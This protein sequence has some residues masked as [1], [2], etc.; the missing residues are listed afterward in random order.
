M[1]SGRKYRARRQLKILS[2]TEKTGRWVKSLS[3]LPVRIVPN[4]HWTCSGCCAADRI[5]RNDVR[6]DSED[7]LLSEIVSV[8]IQYSSVFRHQ[9][10]SLTGQKC[11]L[12]TPQTLQCEFLERTP[13]IMI[14]IHVTVIFG[15][16][17]LLVVGISDMHFVVGAQEDD[18]PS[19]GRTDSDS[20][21]VR[22]AS[23]FCGHIFPLVWRNCNLA[24]APSSRAT[25]T[26]STKSHWK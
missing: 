8:C 21:G 4:G 3:S 20:V 24:P 13:C 18:L 15:H 7:L 1:D 10:L 14:R 2:T 6:N 26:C 17:E 22:S 19:C 23:E 5:G 9:V 12:G 16:Q 11:V 25:E